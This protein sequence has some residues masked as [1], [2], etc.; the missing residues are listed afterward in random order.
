MVFQSCFFLQLPPPAP[1]PY[2]YQC[3]CASY[4][5]SKLQLFAVSSTQANYLSEKLSPKIAFVDWNFER[6]DIH[7]LE[8][9]GGRWV[10]TTAP[11][12]EMTNLWSR[13]HFYGNNRNIKSQ[14]N[15]A[16]GITNEIP[17][18]RLYI[19][20]VFL[21]AYLNT[22]DFCCIWNSSVLPLPIWRH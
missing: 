16:I 2:A 8:L 9:G 15:K 6:K 5:C 10:A 17:S 4:R 21:A 11:P 7:I 1:C 19:I 20:C 13:V 3:F 18:P 22:R 14:E 12:A